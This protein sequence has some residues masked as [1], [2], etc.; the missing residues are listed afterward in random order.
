MRLID[1]TSITISPERQ[2]QE[3][4]GALDIEGLKKSILERGLIHAI[5]LTEAGHL[6]AGH[7]RLLALRELYAD[8][9]Q[10]KHDGEMIPV[11]MIPYTHLLEASQVEL[12]EVE[13]DENFWR[14]NLTWQ[15]QT[16]AHVRIHE[17]RLA[18]NPAQT[19]KATSDELAATKAAAAGIPVTPSMLAS[20]QV[21]LVQMKAVVENL[22][23]PVV[24]NASS[25][26]KAYTALLDA[27]RRRLERDLI[28]LDPKASPHTLHLGDFRTIVGGFTIG[29]Y[30]GVVAD[31]PYGINAHKSGNSS[32]GHQYDDSPT[33]AL[34]LYRELFRRAWMLLKPMGTIFVFCDIEHFIAIRTMAEQQAFSTFRT[35]I[36]WHKGSEGHAPWGREGPKRVYEILLLAVKGQRPLALS[37][38]PDVIS[39][40]R[41][42]VDPNRTHAAEKPPELLR[43]LVQKAFRSGDHILDP[44]CGTGP[45]FTAVQGL[46][47]HV[48]G[49]ELNPEYHE[50][51]ASR[52]VRLSEG[53]EVAP[54][55]LTGHPETIEDKLAAIL[56][57][58]NAQ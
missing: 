34:D 52:L 40:P 2:R 47:I 12:L 35:P 23:N 29:T 55:S 1:A 9:F 39:I 10:I 11:G 5:I 32:L 53:N 56:A 4:L 45:I 18:Q 7:R 36:I 20:E 19:L 44:C 57:A 49:I 26:R 37:F 43:Y 27:E 22:H 24:A 58:S 38:G 41:P 28:R 16:R 8:G 3:G 42:T 33:H 21:K 50:Q 13:Y 30:D 48:T 6:V 15:E 17:L 31:L 46:G 51:A 25:P 54:A 14:L